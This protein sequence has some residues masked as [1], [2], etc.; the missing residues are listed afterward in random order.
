MNP[1]DSEGHVVAAQQHQPHAER[2]L[3]V[4]MHNVA[5]NKERF[6]RSYYTKSKRAIEKAHTEGPAAWLIEADGDSPGA[7]GAAGQP[8]AAAQ[9]RDPSARRSGDH[10]GRLLARRCH[11]GD[12]VR[13]RHL[14]GAHGPAVQPAAGHA[15]GLPVLQPARPVALRRHRL[16]PRRHLQRA[17]LPG[18]RHL[19][20][21]R[22]HDAGHEMASDARRHRCAA[23]RSAAGRSVP[24][25]PC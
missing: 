13:R 20:P 18:H 1:P 11:R 12:G 5:T 8:V 16:D 6:L 23:C 22:R 7:G 9:D 2:I 17:D 4:G 10:R 15:D 21:R 3:L 19:D 25:A 14:R 24:A